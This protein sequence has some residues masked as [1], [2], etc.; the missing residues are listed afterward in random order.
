MNNTTIAFDLEF[1]SG[2]EI[3]VDGTILVRLY[4]AFFTSNPATDLAFVTNNMKWK[5]YSLSN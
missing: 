3:L 2:I 4:Y 5:S 1:E